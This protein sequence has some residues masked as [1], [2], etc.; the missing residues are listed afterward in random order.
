[1][2][3]NRNPKLRSLLVALPAVTGVALL[4]SGAMAGMPSGNQNINGCELSS[5]NRE[6]WCAL[7]ARAVGASMG[8]TTVTWQSSLGFHSANG[9]NVGVNS[10]YTASS[11][12]KCTNGGTLQQVV[13]INGVPTFTEKGKD[14]TLGQGNYTFV[15][16]NGGSPMQL[17][18]SAAGTTCTGK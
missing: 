9:W 13:Y 15:C 6:N 1:M 2:T 10:G 11:T 18:C 4:S 17:W 7:G 8:P 16:A 3:T 5:S 14:Q 12:F